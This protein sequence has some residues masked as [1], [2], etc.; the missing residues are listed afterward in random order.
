MLLL[1]GFGDQITKVERMGMFVL[2]V[3]IDKDNEKQTRESIQRTF[4]EKDSREVEGVF[5]ESGDVY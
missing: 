4:H 5:G 3:E 2:V 1:F